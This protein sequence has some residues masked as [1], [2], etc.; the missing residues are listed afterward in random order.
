MRKKL[1]VVVCLLI[2]ILML[3]GCGKNAV[4]LRG[5]WMTIRESTSFHPIGSE[6]WTPPGMRS[7]C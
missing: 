6:S 5:L 3:P 7:K 2:L 1:L 4:R